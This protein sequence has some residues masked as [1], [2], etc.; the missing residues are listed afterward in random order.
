MSN[1][2]DQ[3][4]ND[5]QGLEDY[6]NTAAAVAGDEEATKWMEEHSDLWTDDANN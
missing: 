1:I 6:E 2:W 5:K 4:A 3:A